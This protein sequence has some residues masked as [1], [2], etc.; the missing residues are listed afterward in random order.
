MYMLPHATFRGDGRGL[1]S[2][3]CAAH[4][5]DKRE[6]PEQ[7]IGV[8]RARRRETRDCLAEKIVKLFTQADMEAFHE[9]SYEKAKGYLTEEVVDKW[10]N[11]I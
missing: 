6:Q 2:L 4:G 11:L 3:V 7:R 9:H 8:W 10:K 5:K 1:R